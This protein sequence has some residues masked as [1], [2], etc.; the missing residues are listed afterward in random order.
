M[1]RW[2]NTAQSATHDAPVVHWGC[3]QREENGHTF[4]FCR[5]MMLTRAA[6]EC[7]AC[8]MQHCRWQ[9]LHSVRSSSLRCAPRHASRFAAA[10][11]KPVHVVVALICGRHLCDLQCSSGSSF[12]LRIACMQKTMLISLSLAADAESPACHPG[13]MG[14]GSGRCKQRS[15]RHLCRSTGLRTVRVCHPQSVHADRLSA[16]VTVQ[17]VSMSS[18]SWVVPQ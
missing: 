18:G 11:H 5:V 17:R 13:H 1:R 9:R 12:P 3:T 15:V 8:S 14:Q 16:D 7:Q 2:H 6:C 4:A 10:R